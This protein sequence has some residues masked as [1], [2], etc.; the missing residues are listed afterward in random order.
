MSWIPSPAANPPPLALPR[1]TQPGQPEGQARRLGSRQSPLTTHSSPWQAGA[2]KEDVSSPRPLSSS[3]PGQDP[4]RKLCLQCLLPSLSI[5]FREQRELMLVVKTITV[6]RELLGMHGK[7]QNNI[8]QCWKFPKMFSTASEEQ[9][10]CINSGGEGM[11]TVT[12][13]AASL[14][15]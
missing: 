14:T 3:V 9:G 10:K 5:L 2:S 7:L 4:R 15:E 6:S 12:H 13:L 11:H 8:Q 1:P